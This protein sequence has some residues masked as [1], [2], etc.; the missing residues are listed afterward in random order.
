MNKRA[1]VKLFCLLIATCGLE[2][3][4]ANC[5]F[6]PLGLIAWWRAEGNALD[7]VG[8]HPGT[9]TG[10][11]AFAPG[12]VGQAFSFNASADAG[13]IVPPATSLNPTEAITIEAWIRPASFPN[14]FPTVVRKDQNAIGTTQ[15]SLLV[16]DRVAYLNIGGV[17]TATGGS[18]PTNVW[19]HLAGTYDRQFI[20]LYVN[21]VE[22]TN[23]AATAAIPTS[24]ENLGIGK[25]A[26]FTTRNFDGLIDEVS[27]YSRALS[28]GEIAAIH[29]AG[30]AGKCDLRPKLNLTPLPGAVRLTW[31]TN[32]PG[33]L[34][35]T[36][37]A[38]TLPA[39]W[40]VLTSNYSVIETNFAV[41]NAVGDAT[42]FYRL[43][44]P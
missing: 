29:A 24:T 36:N 8:N 33:F 21:G 28:A 6:A 14:A 43:H 12:H 31:T 34:L 42:R 2:A 22:V 7:T 3:A 32:A 1:Y 17:G 19:T 11:V 35:Q 16:G 18:V 37:S 44:K 20:R 39:G 26:L 25:H 41:T 23:T 40:G 38:F 5:T 9:P 13:I 4:R 30:S 27:I 15:Y 10:G